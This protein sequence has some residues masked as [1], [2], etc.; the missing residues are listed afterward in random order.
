M[1][2]LL[3]EEIQGIPIY[4]KESKPVKQ[5]FVG[6]HVVF[7]NK[8]TKVYYYVREKP[9]H[10]KTGTKF[11]S[12][13]EMVNEVP[14]LTEYFSITEEIFSGTVL[15]GEKLMIL[16]KGPEINY[17]KAMLLEKDSWD[18]ENSFIGF[19]TPKGSTQKSYMF[20]TSEAILIKTDD[21]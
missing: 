7:Q 21:N 9:G 11:S 4:F 12:I 6:R 18:D 5:F 13:Y 2:K 10:V 15:K 8:E 16:I 19:V 14:E 20:K 3:V 17:I 1:T